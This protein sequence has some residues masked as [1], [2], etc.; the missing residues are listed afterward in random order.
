MAYLCWKHKKRMHYSNHAA[1][2]SLF[3]CLV[4]VSQLSQVSLTLYLLGV[5]KE[6]S[7]VNSAT[8]HGVNGRLTVY[9]C[10]LSERV[11]S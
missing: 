9:G 8:L 7:G 6:L 5:K 3:M 11:S 4:N 1:V 10:V 2:H